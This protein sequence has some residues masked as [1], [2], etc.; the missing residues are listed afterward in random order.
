M[1][2]TAQDVYTTLGPRVG[3]PPIRKQEI[4]RVVRVLNAHR[5]CTVTVGTPKVLDVP[6]A[7]QDPTTITPVAPL[8]TSSAGTHEGFRNVDTPTSHR[9]PA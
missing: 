8:P 6:A 9:G 4:D 3:Y 5:H 7:S 1:T 2:I